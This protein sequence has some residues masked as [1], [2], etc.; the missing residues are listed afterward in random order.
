MCTTH[1]TFVSDVLHAFCWYDCIF[2]ELLKTTH[3][4]YICVPVT[5]WWR[6]NL[7]RMAYFFCSYTLI[8]RRVQNVSLVYRDSFNTGSIFFLF[9][10]SLKI[11]RQERNLDFK[12]HQYPCMRKVSIWI[13]SIRSY[14][15]IQLH[16]WNFMNP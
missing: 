4:A 11:Q 7:L 1:T 9:F 16:A 14:N 3:T 13:T 5:R 2:T 8:Y 12:L 15:P 6:W 10:E